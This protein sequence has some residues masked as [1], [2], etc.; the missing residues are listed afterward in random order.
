MKTP[1]PKLNAR[2]KVLRDSFTIAEAQLFGQ[3]ILTVLV[4]FWVGDPRSFWGLGIF[5][6]SGGFCLFILKTHEATHPFFIDLLWPKFWLYTIPIWWVIL[7]FCVGLLQN[8]I[9]EIE[10]GEEIYRLLEPTSSWLP[11]STVTTTT[12]ITVIGF[13]AL[14]L[15]S[16]N[17]YL[18]PKSRS[19]FEKTLPWFCLVAVLVCVFGYIQEVLSLQKPLLTKGTGQNDFFSFFTYDGHWAAFALIWCSVCISLALLNNRYEDSADFIQ[20]SGPWYL[21]GATLLGASGILVEA[22][23]PSAVLLI[24]FSIMLLLVAGHFLHYKKNTHS[25]NIAYAS[26]LCATTFSAIAIYRIFQD[27]PTAETSELLRQAAINM[28]QDRPV[29]GWGLD[30]FQQMAP[31]YLD[32]TLLGARHDRVLSDALQYLAELGI[33]GITIPIIILGIPLVNYFRKKS[34]VMMT[35]HLLIG[36]AGVLALSFMDT[37]FMS[38]AVFFSFFIVVFS[39][40]R[41]ADLSR[42]NVD[43]VD[44]VER[45][46][47]VSPEA[48]RRLPFFTEDYTEAEK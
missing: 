42:S 21:T 43:E 24:G 32:D 17:L 18:I 38:P 9:A 5:M 40:L 14:Y 39:A 41:W 7:Q 20:S 16:L 35:N 19:F 2:D 10:V 15:I 34:D 36:C 31:F 44:A 1:E 8:P 45:P 28:F 30:S 4:A 26:G 46:N 6:I 47:L 29:F 23:W 3:L 27:N 48:E 33:V 12:W 25:K 22:R 37:P 13:C 11:I